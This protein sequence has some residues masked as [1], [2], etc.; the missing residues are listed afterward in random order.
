[1]AAAVAVATG[2]MGVAAPASASCGAGVGV[3]R[4]T[5]IRPPGVTVAKLAASVG[6][7]PGAPPMQASRAAAREKRAINSRRGE[8]SILP[9]V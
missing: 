7:S 6:E 2:P 3:S 4:E 1:M 5:E 9:P 8:G